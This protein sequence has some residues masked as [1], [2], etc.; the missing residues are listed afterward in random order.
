MEQHP[1]QYVGTGKEWGEFILFLIRV[2][3][4]IRERRVSV[5]CTGLFAL[6]A[7]A[8]VTAGGRRAMRVWFQRPVLN[9]EV[10]EFILT[11]VWA[12]R[13]MTSLFFLFLFVCR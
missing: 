7:Y 4:A 8:C 2:I 11:S 12:I 1:S 13:S 3:M 6:C 9:L 5:L 10:R